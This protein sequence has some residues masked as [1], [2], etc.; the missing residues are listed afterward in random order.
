MDGGVALIPSET[1]TASEALYSNIV[2][3]R[4]DSTQLNQRFLNPEKHSEIQFNQSPLHVE[5][6]SPLLLGRHQY[7]LSEKNGAHGDHSLVPDLFTLQRRV[8]RG[9]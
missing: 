4:V 7:I 6:R 1:E 9:S 8:L 5:N 3:M 2:F